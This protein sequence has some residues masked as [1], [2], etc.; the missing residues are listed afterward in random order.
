MK[1]AASASCIPVTAA[2]NS[3]S[4]EMNFKLSVIA[5]KNCSYYIAFEQFQ[6]KRPDH[7]FPLNCWKYR[8]N[9]DPHYEFTNPHLPDPNV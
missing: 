8:K 1:K 7:C 3:L 2:L 9:S 6:L 4:F 5:K